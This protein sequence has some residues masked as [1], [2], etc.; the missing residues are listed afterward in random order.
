MATVAWDKKGGLL[1]VFMELGTTIT[2]D[3]YR[4]ETMLPLKSDT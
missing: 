2:Q 4:Y 1:V 3:V